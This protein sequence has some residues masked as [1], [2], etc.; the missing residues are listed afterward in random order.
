MKSSLRSLRRFVVLAVAAFCLHSQLRG[1]SL[2]P[3]SP[4]LPLGR[5]PIPKP[6]PAFTPFNTPLPSPTPAPALWRVDC[7]ITRLGTGDKKEGVE[8]VLVADLADAGVC[9][10]P[11]GTFIRASAHNSD[12]V[13]GAGVITKWSVVP[14]PSK[15]VPSDTRILTG[16]GRSSGKPSVPALKVGRTF[17]LTVAAITSEPVSVPSPAPSATP[18]SGASAVPVFIPPPAGTKAK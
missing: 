1:Q 14:T 3:V 18:T 15:T 12:D 13:L 6:I 9:L 5:H 7:K 2:A 10:V 11:K 4:T 16:E 8:A 17:E